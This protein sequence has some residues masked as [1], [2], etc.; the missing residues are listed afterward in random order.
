MKAEEVYNISI[1]LPEKELERL[2]AFI[3]NRL[4]KCVLQNPKKVKPKLITEDEAT[5]F[6]LKTVFKVN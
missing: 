4:K 2:S 1:Y 5:Q 6:I 3:S